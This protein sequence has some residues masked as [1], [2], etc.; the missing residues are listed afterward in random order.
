[1]SI[2]VSGTEGYA[3]EAQSLLKRWQ[4]ISFAD[5]HGPIVHLIPDVPSK[6]LDIGSGVGTD[7]AAFASM[8]HYSCTVSVPHP[9]SKSTG[10]RA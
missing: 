3:E 8:G 4:T 7:A 2:Y 10:T 5:Q 1:M 6:V 9:F